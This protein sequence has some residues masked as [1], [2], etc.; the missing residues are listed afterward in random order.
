MQDSDDIRYMVGALKGLGI[1]LQ[2]DWGKGECTVKVGARVGG[3]TCGRE[4]RGGQG[5]PNWPV[6][7]SWGDVPSDRASLTRGSAPPNSPQSRLQKRRPGPTLHAHSL[8]PAGVWRAVP[9]S[10]R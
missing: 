3:C 8:L 1:E 6:L 10:G 7:G 9:L 4:V 5:Q 2:E